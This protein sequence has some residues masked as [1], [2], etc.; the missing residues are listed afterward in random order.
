MA[1]QVATNP[2]SSRRTELS[3]SGDG[4]AD[5]GRVS[6]G[7][8]ELRQRWYQAHV[9]RFVADQGHY[10]EAKDAT[11]GFR[12]SADVALGLL[13]DLRRTGDLDRFISDIRKWAVAPGT[14]DFNGFAGQL[15]LNQL[16]DRTDEPQRFTHLLVESLTVPAS[17][18]EAV[19][20]LTSMVDY[21]KSIKVGAH[22]APGSVPFL[23]SYFW[24]LA[25]WDRWPVMW[26]SAVRF[27][28]FSTGESFPGDPPE[29]YRV[30]V[31]RVRELTS[32]HLEFEITAAWWQ[33]QRPVFVDEVLA[34]R[35]AFGLDTE[36]AVEGD[37]EIN[38]RALVSIAKYW[39]KRLAGDV[40]EALGPPVKVAVPKDSSARPDLWVDWRIK[41][42]AENGLSMRLWV[43]DQGVAVALR[44]GKKQRDWWNEAAPMFAAGNYP[45]SPVLEV[46]ESQ[47]GQEDVRFFQFRG[48]F[49]YGRWF[50]RKEFHDLDLAGNLVEV[51]GLL[52]PMFDE[53]LAL[54][55]GTP[56]EPP[57]GG[58]EMPGTGESD[59]DDDTDP[60]EALAEELL[61]QK[62]FLDDAVAPLEDKGQVIFYGPPGTGKTYL[63]RKLAEVLA[64]DPSRR[65][66]V[67][68]HPSSSYEDFFEGYRPEA[69]DGD[70]THRLTPGPLALMGLYASK[71]G[72]RVLIFVTG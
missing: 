32:D 68:F 23:L 51:A 15:L 12:T 44:P 65:A 55:K 57:V 8:I 27:I 22:P 36:T 64:P 6:S 69:V 60:I 21:V 26:A 37:L 4:G 41:E 46:A 1:D 14:L 10:Q 16:Y 35:A 11:D 28:E 49:V 40:A 67:Q 53:L 54:A 45:A 58:D 33:N 70:M 3:S 31:K 47:L 71:L 2:D 48:E 59:T 18:Q 72:R 38:A 25:D 43:N 52:K 62:G 17:D 61:I 29:K 42:V 20:K 56:K 39:G 5:R 19:E 50:D 9:G 66:L 63:A 30:F 13:A 34:D 24:G 7:E